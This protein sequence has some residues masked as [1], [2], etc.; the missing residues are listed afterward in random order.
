MLA[1]FYGEFL[2]L[3][4]EPDDAPNLG[5]EIAIWPLVQEGYDGDRHAAAVLDPLWADLNQAEGWL[6]NCDANHKECSLQVSSRQALTSPMLLVCV[7]RSCLVEASGE[8]RY[9]ALSYIWGNKPATCGIL[10]DEVA[11]LFQEN[12]FSK[13]KTRKAV[14]GTLQR[15]FALASRLRIDF[16]WVDCLCIVQDDQ[17]H[18]AQ[19]INQM[20][21]I[22][23]NAYLTV[24]ACDG[25]DANDGLRGISQTHLPRCIQ[26]DILHF[27]KA[28]L[29][30]GWAINIQS[31]SAHGTRAWTFQEEALSPRVLKFTPCGL[32]GSCF[33]E[34]FSE[35]LKSRDKT[36]CHMGG[37][38]LT[39][40]LQNWPCVKSW[41]NFLGGYL[42]RRLRHEMDRLKAFTGLLNALGRST[43][44]GFHYGLPESFF[45]V[46]ML[47]IPENY[48]TRQDPESNLPSWTWAG[49]EDP[50]TSQVNQFG[51]THERSTDDR[52]DDHNTYRFLYPCVTWL[53]CTDDLTETRQIHNDYECHRDDYLGQSDVEPPKDWLVHE[54]EQDGDIFYTF[55][56]AP[57]SHT[58][59]YPVPTHGGSTLAPKP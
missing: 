53:K 56:H 38:R 42:D 34:E 45:D 54:D 21:I 59:W 43:L 12:S 2:Y 36:P 28:N 57:A 49:L 58:F 32:E 47:W 33:I 7:S 15:L 50:I 22:Y 37:T 35:Q 18:F 40:A 26:Q 51:L 44:G 55:K 13:R 16:V 46:A 20:D 4:L 5:P 8:E 41:D 52:S 14:P 1:D 31:R 29:D 10:R 9:I 30:R 11:S 25:D 48:L 24:C 17:I 23:A 27:D 3:R 39:P 6:K 19:Q